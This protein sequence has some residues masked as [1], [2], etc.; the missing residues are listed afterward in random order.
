MRFVQSAQRRRCASSCS[1][2]VFNSDADNSRIV[3]DGMTTS[4]LMNPIAVGTCKW[5]DMQTATDLGESNSSR[6][7]RSRG[8]SAAASIGTQLL[9]SCRRRQKP[10]HN[11]TKWTV[12]KK[13]QTQK[14]KSP[15]KAGIV[16]SDRFTLPEPLEPKWPNRGRAPIPSS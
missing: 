5:S 15:H 11:L 1:R 2:I 7:F 8:L 3:Q 10:T 12:A 6:V 14:K 4:G 13:N 16:I 9:R